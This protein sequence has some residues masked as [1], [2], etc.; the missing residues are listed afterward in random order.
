MTNFIAKI[1][2][3]LINQKLSRDIAYTLC[4]FIVLAASGIIINITITMLR[5]PA[6]LGVFNLTY[7]VY[8]IASQFAVFGIHY[9][10]LRNTTY[11][12]ESQEER[13]KLLGTASVCAFAL[14]VFVAIIIFCLQP[15]FEQLFQSHAVAKA[16]G[17]SSLGL[18]FFPFNKILLAYLN[19]IHEMKAFSILQGV[20]YIS[21]MVVVGLFVASSLPIEYSTLSFFAAEI[22][23]AF[24]ASLYILINKLAKPLT[25]DKSWVIRHFTFG[26]KGLFAGIFA[27]LN[28]RLDVLIIGIFL[29]DFQ[30]GVYSFVAM[31]VDGLYHILAMIRINFNPLLVSMVRDK[32]WGSATQLRTQSA[33]YIAPIMALCSLLIIL[34]YLI[35]AYFIVPD[36]G[37]QFGTL[38][39]LI[40]LTG[41]VTVSSLI[42]FDNL[43]IVSG[44]P[45]YQAV[46]QICMVGSNLIMALILVPFLNIEGAAIATIIGYLIGISVLVFFAKKLVGWSLLTNRY[47][48]VS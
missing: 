45:G 11:Y 40:L 32:A 2:H 18:V 33:K 23:T 28:S 16:I 8:I 19:G 35:F 47:V 46:Q 10:V 41:L 43:L 30:V 37:L 21:V 44:Y 3:Q 15:F 9:S 36:K 7:A 12:K 17:Y 20:R 48:G 6:S 14:G 1:R 5:D 22:I 24:F 38:S 25:F 39:L 27:D 42:P 13:G 26:S 31:L 29:S 4:S 34:C